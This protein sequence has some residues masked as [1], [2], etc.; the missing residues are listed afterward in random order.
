MPLSRS[1]R[2][3]DC[4]PGGDKEHRL[5]KF[6]Y[7]FQSAQTLTPPLAKANVGLTHGLKM[8]THSSHAG[9]EA[10]AKLRQSGINIARR[11]VENGTRGLC[12]TLV[13]IGIHGVLVEYRDGLSH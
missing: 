6:D 13:G 12:C 9:P 7:G 5:D 2:Q 10:V 8:S 11:T 4:A 1:P 3:Q